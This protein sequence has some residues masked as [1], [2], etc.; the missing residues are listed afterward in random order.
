MR[1]RDI[2]PDLFT[3]T[4]HLAIEGDKLVPYQAGLCSLQSQ[5][6]FQTLSSL[7]I[8]LQIKNCPTTT[9]PNHGNT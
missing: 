3:A 1:S 8:A 4:R 9:L 7:E 6:P 2:T 5:N